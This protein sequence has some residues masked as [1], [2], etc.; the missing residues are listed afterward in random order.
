VPL[1]TEAADRIY[2]DYLAALNAKDRP[3]ARSLI[4]SLAAAAADPFVCAVLSPQA[5][6]DAAR[7]G[8]IVAELFVAEAEEYFARG[9]SAPAFLAY[10]GALESG[11]AGESAFDVTELT[12]WVERALAARDRSA[13]RAFSSALEKTAHAL[14]EGVA[15]FIASRDTVSEMSKGVVTI[16]V[17]KGMRI[18][19]GI[20][21]PDRVLGSG[22]FVDRAGYVLTNYHVIESEVDP[23]YEGYSRLTVRIS[24]D[25]EARIAAKVVGWD[26]L[27]D[28]ALLK[29]DV[30]P[31]YVFSLSAE[32]GFAP[33]DKILAIGSP[34]GLENTVTSGIVSAVG[35]KLLQTGEAIQVDAA[36][37]PGN[38]GGPLVNEAGQAVGIVFAG[39]SQFQ[40]LNFAIPSSWALRALPALFRG[41]ELKRAWLGLALAES[42]GG[43]DVT[44]RH[45]RVAAGI[46]AGDRLLSVDG[47]ETTLLPAAQALLSDRFPGGL[48][49]VRVS[50]PSGDRVLL[51]RLGERP[52][53][54]IED[55]FAIDRRDRLLAP[56]FGMEAM[57]QPGTILEPEAYNVVRVW[58]GTVA[59]EAGLS[60]NDPFAL[61]RF[62]VDEEQRAAV[63]YIRVKKRKAGFLESVLQ[64]PAPLEVPTFL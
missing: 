47:I 28:L 59:D 61:R 26:R 30:K 55:A 17:D 45:P 1:A 16:R 58:P 41:G 49:R 51:R 20:G 15:Q 14:P 18:E 50:G 4:E 40:G 60:E 57:R 8:E 48:V 23:K 37:N 3:A 13:L 27:L 62:Y 42:K 31:A 32:G 36:L 35:R 12:R 21:L 43:L 2:A 38:S 33:G 7:S 11:R 63:I 53:S 10:E 64:L 52:F 29:V 5:S 34:V 6:A 24:E 44:Y 19:Q 39:L 54:P 46:E 22:F 25:P 56:L 9:L